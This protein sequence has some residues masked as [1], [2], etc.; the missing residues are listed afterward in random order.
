MLRRVAPSRRSSR[1]HHSRLPGVLTD[2][3]LERL[4]R[5]TTC[6]VRSDERKGL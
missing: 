2:V 4:R 5:A 6:A 1:S 3:L